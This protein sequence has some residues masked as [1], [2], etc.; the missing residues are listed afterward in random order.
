[1]GTLRDYLEAEGTLAPTEA[2]R[3]GARIAHG[4][5]Q[6][7]AA[8]RVHRA[9]TP[10][11]T[12]LDEAGQVR[13][14]EPSAEEPEPLTQLYLAPELINGQWPTPEADLYS[15]GVLLY[16]MLCGLPPF[17]GLTRPA[18]LDAH[19]NLA[20]G[21]IPGL[22]DRLWAV[23]AQL[24]DK[25]PT[26]RPSDAA[27]V[28]A[29]LDAL[30][31]QIADS[32]ALPLLSAP[33]APVLAEI[34]PASVAPEAGASESV[35]PDPASGA[36]PQLRP[37]RTPALVGVIAG[38]LIV[39]AGLVIFVV[40]NER[41]EPVTQPTPTTPD[42]TTEAA[43]PTPAPSPSEELSSDPPTTSA[44]PS[45]WPPAGTTLCR[46]TNIAVN[47]V[48][49]C[50]FATNVAIAYEESG[51][52]RTIEAYSPVTEQWYDMTCQQQPRDIVRCAGGNNA[53]VYLRS[54]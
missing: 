2:C 48:T 50:E 13:L 36:P 53:Q 39:L 19:L 54:A 38:L 45:A 52:A 41:A 31:S 23:I 18:F 10:E 20:P 11:L 6:L 33:P 8:G 4:L 15:L 35:A 42:L 47:E 34:E 21:P 3:L 22:D 43:P 32:P 7:H 9:L 44:P 51:G 46:D 40:W 16:E 27:V 24:L 14:V 12:R 1:M 49:S 25:E 28:E 5:T 17:A 26:R 30:G 37:S 29:G